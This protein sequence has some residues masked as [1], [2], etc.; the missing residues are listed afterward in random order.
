VALFVASSVITNLVAIGLEA[1]RGWPLF[2]YACAPNIEVNAIYAGPAV[3]TYGVLGLM[4]LQLAVFFVLLRLAPLT[5]THA[6]EHMVVHAIEDGDDLTPAKVAAKPRVHPRCGTNLMA[7]AFIILAGGWV[8]TAMESRLGSAGSLLGFGLLLLVVYL[9][10][11]G[12]GAGLQ[13]FITTKRP[14]R[15]QIEGAIAAATQL[16]ERY[17]RNPSRR[18]YG[19]RRLWY[20][21][22]IQ[23]AAGFFS[24][25]VAADYLATWL[26]LGLAPF[27]R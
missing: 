2:A 14:S 27:G 25:W 26:H 3:A 18:A 1:W 7:L 12:I 4:G 23:V 11:R 15:R 19:I 20:I 5:G 24:A 10:W 9:V 21:G 8:L 13:R 22:I 17:Q 16:L 6:A